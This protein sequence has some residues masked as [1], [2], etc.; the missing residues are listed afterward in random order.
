VQLNN[1]HALDPHN[2]WIT[3]GAV[4]YK[5]A[6]LD[7]GETATK[8]V[9]LT[10]GTHVLR[11]AFDKGAA[12]LSAGA[13]N[14]F[15]FTPVGTITTDTSAF[16]LDGGHASS[17]FGLFPELEVKKS[18]VGYNRESYLKFDISTIGTLNSAKLLLFGRL[19]SSENPSINLLVNDASSNWNENTITWNNRP[20]AQQFIASFT[21]TGTN[22]K[23]YEIDMTNYLKAAKAAGK[24]TVTFV[25]RSAQTTTAVCNFNSDDNYSCQ[26]HLA[27]T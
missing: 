9:A 7:K 22:A 10:A 4:T 16:V 21:V 20:P 27:I 12:N 14:Y 24:T 15:T 19:A 18:T 13:V 8:Q 25:I 6:D 3:K 23:W 26:P 11:L 17:N 1:S 2:L 5:F